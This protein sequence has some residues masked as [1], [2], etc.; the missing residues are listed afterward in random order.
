MSEPIRYRVDP[1][2]DVPPSRQLT[3]AILDAVATGAV[4]PGEKLPTVKGLA[5]ETLVNPNTAAKAYRML[6]AEGVLIGKN[7]LGVFVAEGGPRIARS[8]R[9]RATLDAFERAALVALRAGNDPAR[10]LAI[11]D[12][13]AAVHT[14]DE[15]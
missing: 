3:E 8:A 11:L 4:G 2:L 14:G 6:Q 7:G 15:R 10:L 1:S 12:N 9:R 5:A 13:H